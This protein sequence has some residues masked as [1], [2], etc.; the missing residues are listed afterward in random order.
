MGLWGIDQFR[1]FTPVCSVLGHLRGA[2]IEGLLTL[3]GE[4]GVVAL[5]LGL[6]VEHGPGPVC[7]A[8]VLVAGE[9][10]FGSTFAHRVTH[11]RKPCL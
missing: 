11:M 5:L 7:L 2:H 9:G 6:R 4:D 1:R 10:L 3:L 8:V